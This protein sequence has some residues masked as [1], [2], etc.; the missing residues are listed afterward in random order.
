MHL[1]KPFYYASK[2]KP[3]LPEKKQNNNF[4][5]SQ[6]QKT[7]KDT[8][9]HEEKTPEKTLNNN[10]GHVEE[11][12]HIGSQREFISGFLEL[13]VVS[14]K[15]IIAQKESDVRCLIY[16]PDGNLLHTNES[17][18]ITNPVWDF[19]CR[20]TINIPIEQREPLRVLVVEHHL[21][22]K[23]VLGSVEISS[24]VWSQ[25]SEKWITDEFLPLNHGQGEIHIRF[26]FHQK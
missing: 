3:I 17:T 24:D 12:K 10:I 5:P 11:Q 22:I 19:S 25:S 9:Q 4:N 6:D 21:S 2:S 8:Q 16:L 14:A 23:K 15:N 20:G 26:R 7:T 1:K 18:E 13:N